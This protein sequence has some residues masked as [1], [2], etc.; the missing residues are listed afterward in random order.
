MC[1]FWCD[2]IRTQ[3]MGNLMPLSHSNIPTTMHLLTKDHD[4]RAAQQSKTLA[5]P[6]TPPPTTTATMTTRPEQSAVYRRIQ[7]FL[8]GPSA[9]LKRLNGRQRIPATVVAMGTIVLLWLATAIQT[10]RLFYGWK[11]PIAVYELLEKAVAPRLTSQ[12]Y[13]HN[14]NDGHKPTNNDRSDQLRCGHSFRLPVDGYDRLRVNAGLSSKSAKDALQKSC[15]WT[16]DGSMYP[17]T[18]IDAVTKLTPQEHL[19]VF[20][21]PVFPFSRGPVPLLLIGTRLGCARVVIVFVAL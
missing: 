15:R 7:S 3:P 21:K 6:P 20:F 19:H 9:Y 4:E 5:Q 1:V 8:S 10:E 14:G 16:T 17:Y 18:R 2:W 12:T 11:K 13:Q